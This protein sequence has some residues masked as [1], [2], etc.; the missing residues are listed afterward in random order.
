MFCC[1]ASVTKPDRS[2]CAEK[3]SP[4]PA[5]ANRAFTMSRAA[6]P[7]RPSEPSFRVLEDPAE[8]GPEVMPLA[9]IA[10]AADPTTG[11]TSSG[12]SFPLGFVWGIRTF[13]AIGALCS[14]KS[15]S[16]NSLRS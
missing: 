12:R 16:D 15:F 13:R 6:V 10:L 3:S 14:K 4:T 8:E 7:E 5:S 1:P 11:L 9:F 2:E